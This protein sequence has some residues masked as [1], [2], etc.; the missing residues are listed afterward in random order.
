MSA[1][2]PTHTYPRRCPVCR[3]A[4]MGERSDP[5]KGEDDRFHCT[6]CGTIIELHEHR[7]GRRDPN[8]RSRH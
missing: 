5:S 1:K 4:M 7:N 3:I 2:E 6:S 8:E